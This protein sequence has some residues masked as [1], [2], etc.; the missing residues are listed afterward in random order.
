[1]IFSILMRAS[2]RHTQASL[3]QVNCC[4]IRK[5]MFSIKLF[6]KVADSCTG[7]QR[8]ASAILIHHV[9]AMNALTS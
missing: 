4:Q 1:M 7:Q 5:Q 2:F 8:V 9:I 3:Y 6:I